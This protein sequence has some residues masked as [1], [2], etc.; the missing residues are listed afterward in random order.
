M[1]HHLSTIVSP[2]KNH[3]FSS[4]EKIASFPGRNPIAQFLV[5]KNPA[6]RT[7]RCSSLQAANLK[8]SRVPISSNSR[9]LQKIGGKEVLQV[10]I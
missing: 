10:H 5:A 3:H 2:K 4:P 1:I 8:F 6:P 7:S 9:T